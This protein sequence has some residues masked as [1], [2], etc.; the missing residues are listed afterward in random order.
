MTSFLIHAS[1]WITGFL[2]LLNCACAFIFRRKRLVELSSYLAAALVELGIFI[3]VLLLQ[4]SIL[5]QVP[6]H[7]P[8]GLPV[9]RAEIGSALAIGLGLFPVAYWHRSSSKHIREMMAKEAQ[10]MRAREASVRVRSN[11]PGEWMN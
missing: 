9:N 10:E 6:Y 3:F 5:K 2:F 7:L 8:P 4:F 11:A 1:S